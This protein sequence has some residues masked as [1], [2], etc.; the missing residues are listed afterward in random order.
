MNDAPPAPSVPQAA[1]AVGICAGLF[2]VVAHLRRFPSS[3]P[4]DWVIVVAA[5]LVLVGFST[6]FL[7]A[8]WLGFA[9]LALLFFSLVWIAEPLLLVVLTCLAVLHWTGHPRAKS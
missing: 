4:A 8:A 5:V 1:R 7:A 6:R 3:L 9:I 2:L